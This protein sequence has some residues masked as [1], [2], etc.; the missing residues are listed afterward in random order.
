MLLN[1]CYFL[2]DVVV[3]FN[4][5]TIILFSV[6]T[7]PIDYINTY[8]VRLIYSF[9]SSCLLLNHSIWSLDIKECLDSFYFHFLKILYLRPRRTTMYKKKALFNHVCKLQFR[10][11]KI[12][13]SIVY[14]TGHSLF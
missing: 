3:L 5:L 10:L 12:S 1:F 4:Y 2:K 14:H 6:F 7:F 11:L 9:I 13:H 8:L